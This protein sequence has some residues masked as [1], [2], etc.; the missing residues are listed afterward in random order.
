MKFTDVNPFN[1]KIQKRINKS[2]LD[3]VKKKDFI[4]GNNVNKFEKKFSI[5]SKSKYN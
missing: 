5:L 4:L 1:K 3:T 2:I